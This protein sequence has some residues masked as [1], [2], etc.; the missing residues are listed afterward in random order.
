MRHQ[1][2]FTAFALSLLPTVIAN[3]GPMLIFSTG[4]PDGRMA[5]ASR[6][7]STGEFE[8]ETADDFVLTQGASISGASFIGLLTNQA[9]PS[10]LL[11]VSVEI[12]RVFPL[13]SDLTRTSGPASFSTSSVPTRVN[14]PADVAFDSRDSNSASLSFSSTLLTPSFTTLNSIQAGGIQPTPNQTTGGNGPITG[15]EVQIDVTFDT[16]ID[17]A[18]GHY[19]FVP[20]VE[21]SGIDSFL[22]LSAPRPISFGTGP[23]SPDLQAWTRDAQLDPDWLRVGTDIVG[24]SPAPTFNGAFSLL[25]TTVDEPES[26]ALIGIALLALAIAKNRERPRLVI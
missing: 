14:S 16:P 12:Y 9:S 7:A 1:S 3:A 11:S 23:F 8:I 13:D 26:T 2:L 5:M 4:D 25:A 21:V 15:Q 24:G 22:W 18:A 6:P 17:L 20:Q 19:F 10:S